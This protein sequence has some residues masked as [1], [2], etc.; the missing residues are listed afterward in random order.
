M[1][2]VPMVVECCELSMIGIR[3]LLK[4]AQAVLERH[5]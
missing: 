5:F 2:A 4:Q 3:T 1:N